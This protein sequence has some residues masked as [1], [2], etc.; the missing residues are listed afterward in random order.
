MT[1]RA[2]EETQVT[3]SKQEKPGNKEEKNLMEILRSLTRIYLA[4]E[5]MDKTLAFYEDIF[6]PRRFR[7]QYAG[8]ELASVGPFFLCAGSDEAL[9]PYRDTGT[10]LIVD[11]LTDFEEKLVKSEAEILSEP[12]KLPTGINMVVRHHDG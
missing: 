8:L 5:A 6:G 7:I 1:I 4:P 2:T 10:I 9:E 12:M 11:S 3:I